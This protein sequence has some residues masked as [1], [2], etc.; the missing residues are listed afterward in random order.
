MT[1][2]A[3]SIRSA[4]PSMV[5]SQGATNEHRDHRSIASFLRDCCDL[6]D[7]QVEQIRVHQREHGTRFDDAAIALRFASKEDVTRALSQHFHHFHRFSDAS[8]C[9]PE[10]VV[11]ADPFGNQADAFREFCN[12]LLMGVLSS[13]LPRKALAV[14]SFDNGV[15]KTY[16]A[17]NLAAALAQLRGRTLLVDADLRSPR[18][19]TLFGV[20]GRRGLS[21]ILARRSEA[22]VGHPGS[23]RQHEDAGKR[24]PRHEGPTPVRGPGRFGST[25]AEAPE[26]DA[27]RQVAQLPQLY[28]LPAGPVPR[29]PL[30][31]LQGGEFTLLLQRLSRTFDHV[32][33]DT[34]AVARGPEARLIAVKSGAAVVVGRRHRSAVRPMRKLL[35]TLAQTPTRLAGVLINDY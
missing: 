1:R 35:D 27:I 24:K 20:D 10:L 11:A 31:R 15:G 9:D 28:L 34:P 14:L 29:N 18:L 6:T 23:H 22:D 19:H 30:E 4:K 17:A 8:E 3:F 13:D 25:S 2:F 33:V 26:G 7:E 32:I 16:F 12:Q 21:G 5:D